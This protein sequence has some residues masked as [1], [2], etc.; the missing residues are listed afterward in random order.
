MNARST[1]VAA[2][3][4]AFAL[5]SPLMADQI[6]LTGIVRDFKRGDQNGG[7]NDFETAGSQNKFGHVLNM[8][9][10]DLGADKKPIYNPTRPSS[11]DTMKS[12]T[13]FDQWYRDVIGVNV[14]APLTLTLDNEQ[15]QPGGVYTYQSNSFFPINS[16][17]FGNQGLSKNFH[18]TFELHTNFTYTPNQNFT[19]I[20]DDDVWVYVNGKRTIDI[21]GVHSQVTGSFRLFDG[22]A[23]LTKAHFNTGGYVM[24]L[25]S[26]TE[27]TALQQ[28]WSN[29]GLPGS[30]PIAL[31]DRYID[32]NLNGGF[33][34]TRAVFASNKLSVQVAA[35]NV[36]D[37]VVLTYN[38]GHSQTFTPG[39]N[40]ATLAGVGP[41]ANR[42]I[43]RAVIFAGANPQGQAHASNGATGIN[44][45]LAFFF[46]ERHTTQSNFRIDTSIL[47]NTVQPTTISPLY[48]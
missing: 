11:K 48:D 12:K 24:S 35:A 9:T 20:G 23:W 18:F 6:Q 30:C 21:G 22:K 43:V 33:G 15:S 39:G 40:S 27:L 16:Q 31:N 5:S 14:S 44:C 29:L 25:T 45:T 17:L 4:S 3:C 46:A 38:T 47:L 19:F 32:L 34:D 37:S 36:I 13:T 28:K 26:S 7:H 8:V 2:M 1:I 42:E 10:M 41:H